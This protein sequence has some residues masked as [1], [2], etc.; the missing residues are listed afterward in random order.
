[1][2]KT[3]WEAWEGEDTIKMDLIATGCE[4]VYWLQ[5]AQGRVQW[6]AFVNTVMNL[7]VL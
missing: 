2:G 5:V 1:L 3:T 4:D 7:Q 6:W